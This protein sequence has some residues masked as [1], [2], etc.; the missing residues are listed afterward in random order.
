[1][2]KKIIQ[3]QKIMDFFAQIVCGLKYLHN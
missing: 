2:K 1:M 3:E